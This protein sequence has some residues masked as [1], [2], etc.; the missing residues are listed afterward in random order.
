MLKGIN[1]G[2]KS[3]RLIIK[4]LGPLK[5]VD[6]K[7]KP[8]MVLVGESGSCLLYTSDAADECVNV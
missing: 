5:Y 2:S 4:S 1:V 7:V 6:L 8:F 3:E